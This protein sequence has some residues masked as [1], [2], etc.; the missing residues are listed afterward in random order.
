MFSYIAEK[1][2]DELAIK[3][4]A[5]LVHNTFL[6]DNYGYGGDMAAQNSYKVIATAHQPFSWWKFTG[7]P[8]DSLTKL[9]LLLTLSA[10]E[11]ERFEHIIPGKVQSVHHGIDTDFYHA[12][13]PINTRPFR[14]LFVGSWLRD[15]NMLE[16]VSSNLLNASNEI[17]IDIVYPA[18]PDINNPIFHLCK[19]ER[20]SIHR[21]LS[22]EALRDLYNQSRI[23]FLPLKDGTINNALLEAAACGVPVVTAPIESIKEY[24][25]DSFTFFY[26]NSD[27]CTEYILNTLFDDKLLSQQS[28]AA[29]NHVAYNYSLQQVAKEH[30]AVYKSLL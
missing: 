17:L 27:D 7:K 8:V 21:K 2:A 25:S 26:R 9:S 30:I 18:I 10:F 6:E 20:V 28:A 23:L 14:I 11:K 24:T 16:T 13:I 15:L 4:K 22:D 12:D 19:Y 3:C 29:R 5:K 1:E